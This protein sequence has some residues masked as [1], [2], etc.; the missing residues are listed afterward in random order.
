MAA[1]LIAILDFA[2]FLV[3]EFVHN[4]LKDSL[5]FETYV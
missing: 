4:H 5:Y 3:L 1:I 2:H